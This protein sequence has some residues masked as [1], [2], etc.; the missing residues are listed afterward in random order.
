[1]RLAALFSGGKDSTYALHKAIESGH[2]VK[3]LV[4]IFPEKDSSWMFHYPCIELT[5]LQASAMGIPQIV[6][7]SRGEKEREL[8]DLSR[9]LRKTVGIDGVVSG[10][11][12][13]NY[14]KMRIEKVCEE[15]NLA[16]VT[17]LWGEDQEKLLKEEIGLGF[18]IIITGVYSE[19]FNSNWI[20][21]RIDEKCV[22]ELKGLEEKY[23]IQLSGEGG[24]FETLVLD[25]P[26][27][28]QKIRILEFRVRWDRKTGSGYMIDARAELVK[29]F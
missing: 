20:G 28:K 23:E 9:V 29:K 8:K 21:R 12:A 14:Q 26:L 24:E 17:P 6:G 22:E 5:R 1:M 27:F 19:G 7:R 18:E 4:T 16:C 3:Q 2:E 11:I 13:S 10:A 15:L 25:C